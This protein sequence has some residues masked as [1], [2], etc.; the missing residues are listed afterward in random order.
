MPYKL[1]VG[2]KVQSRTT[3]K[4]GKVINNKIPSN[5]FLVEVKWTKKSVRNLEYL[6]NLE[7][8]AD[9]IKLRK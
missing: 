3:G 9:L 4:V 5:P 1:K 7:S 8:D 6:K 2:D